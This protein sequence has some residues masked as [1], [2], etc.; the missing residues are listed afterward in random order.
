MT[1]RDETREGEQGE[2]EEEEEEEDDREVS[3]FLFGLSA[4]SL[5]SSM[6]TGSEG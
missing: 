5:P 4:S 2:E 1:T 6:N 3:P